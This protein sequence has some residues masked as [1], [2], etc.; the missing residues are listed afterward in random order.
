MQL[1]KD[2]EDVDYYVSIETFFLADCLGGC[3]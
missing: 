2:F 3:V 1:I